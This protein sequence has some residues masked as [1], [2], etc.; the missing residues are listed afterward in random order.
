[1]Q[2]DKYSELRTMV[3]AMTTEERTVV[4]ENIPTDEILFHLSGRFSKLQDTVNKI[5]A[6]TRE[7]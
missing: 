1:M 5:N 4:L 6:I 3:K 2:K 7:V